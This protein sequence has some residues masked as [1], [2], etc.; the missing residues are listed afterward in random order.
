MRTGLKSPCLNMERGRG[1]DAR[2][3]ASETVP[4]QQVK[5]SHVGALLFEAQHRGGVYTECTLQAVRWENP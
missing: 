4:V 1:E 2:D 3:L 5:E